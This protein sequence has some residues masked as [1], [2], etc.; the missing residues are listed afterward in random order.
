MTDDHHRIYERH[1]TTRSPF[2][3]LVALEVAVTDRLDDRTLLDGDT[4]QLTVTGLEV[5]PSMAMVTTEVE[6]EVVV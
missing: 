4:H 1:A 6:S 5:E 2:S 3:S